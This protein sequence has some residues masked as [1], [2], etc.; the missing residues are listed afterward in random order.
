MMPV[1]ADPGYGFGPRVD[2]ADAGGPEYE[3]RQ[4]RS[5]EYTPK[6]GGDNVFQIED[7]NDSLN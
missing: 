7:K 2:S 3:M 1:R 5:D 4:N 6:S